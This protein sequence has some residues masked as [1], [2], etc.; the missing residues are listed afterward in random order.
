MRRMQR[1]VRLVN[2]SRPNFDSIIKKKRMMSMIQPVELVEGLH[3]PSV[4]RGRGLEEEEMKEWEGVATNMPDKFEDVM[5]K[6]EEAYA[7][8]NELKEKKKG[9][10]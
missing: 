9:E 2:R 1:L 10:V 7:K 5:V 3:R 6:K 8:R 4:W